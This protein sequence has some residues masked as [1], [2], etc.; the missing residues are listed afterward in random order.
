MREVYSDKSLLQKIKISNKKSNFT[1]KGARKKEKTKSKFTGRN[2]IIK[3]SPKT[4]ETKKRQKRSM[5]LRT[6]SF[7]R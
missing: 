5:R 2:E 4:K 1:T 7:N 6:G 3:I